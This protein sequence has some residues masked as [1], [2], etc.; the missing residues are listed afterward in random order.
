MGVR[1]ARMD[2][3]GR[4]RRDRGHTRGSSGRPAQLKQRAPATAA[5]RGLVIVCLA[6]DRRGQD[7]RAL[8]GVVVL[9][10]MQAGDLC[11]L[12]A[13][14]LVLASKELLYER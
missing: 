8:R 2:E 9:G 3:V 11:V 4:D 14:A 1:R 5:A 6:V 10:R 7:Q 12:L 13:D